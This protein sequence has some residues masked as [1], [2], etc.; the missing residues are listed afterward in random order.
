MKL[1][2]HEFFRRA[3]FYAAAA[4]LALARLV[5]AQLSPVSGAAGPYNRYY[6]Y[7]NI[8]FLSLALPILFCVWCSG[9][10]PALK[11]EAVL[12]RM[13]GRNAAFLHMLAYC[14]ADAAGFVLLLDGTAFAFL[15]AQLA[16]PLRYA[17]FFTV[18]FLLQAAYF[19]VCA[20]LFTIFELLFYHVIV[21]V[22]LIVLYGALDFAVTNGPPIRWFAVGT[23]RLTV[24]STAAGLS[25][26]RLLLAFALVLAPALFFCV[27]RK[28]FIR[29]TEEKQ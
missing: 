28:D 8:S 3:A 19:L 6:Q 10:N 13:K 14:A 22:L 18:C 23:G 29:R 20:L 24:L 2:L 27:S 25:N 4:A 26:L 5:Q 16:S 12:L 21:G 1:Y 7:F 11:E 17:A 15:F 9:A